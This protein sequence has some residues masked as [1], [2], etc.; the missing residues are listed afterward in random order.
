MKA[1]T[2]DTGIRFSIDNDRVV[3]SFIF[4]VKENPYFDLNKLLKL[5]TGKI[6]IEMET[7]ESLTAED[8]AMNL[9]LGQIRG[10]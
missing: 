5:S 1:I 9:Q 8:T 10:D 2:S 3:C 7:V 4:Y 6:Q